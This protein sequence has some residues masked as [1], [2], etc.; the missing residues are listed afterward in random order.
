MH[1]ILSLAATHL[2]TI[3]SHTHQYYCAELQ[4]QASA[5]SLFSERLSS[6]ITA[7]NSE[8]LIA[9]SILMQYIS[10]SNLKFLDNEDQPG[11]SDDPLFG[12]SSGVKCLYAKTLPTLWGRDSPFLTAVLYTPKV[13]IAEAIIQDGQDPRRFVDH[14]MAI[15]DDPRYRS[16]DLTRDHNTFQQRP[17]SFHGC[18]QPC[19]VRPQITASSPQRACDTQRTDFGRIAERLSLLFCL[20]AMSVSAQPSTSESLARLLPDIERC[21]FTFPVLYSSVFSRNALQHDVRAKVILYHFYR[22]ARLLLTGPA[23]WWACKRSHVLESLFLRELRSKQLEV[24]VLGEG[25]D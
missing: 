4:L 15:W 24:C 2:C 18:P 17:N 25:G 13:A 1:T 3:Q 5:A 9:A 14:F 21:V 23:T 11:L 7:Q 20:V 16:A 8:A 6:P 22:A 19:R 12:L 10:W